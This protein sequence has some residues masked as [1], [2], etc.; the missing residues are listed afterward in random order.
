MAKLRVHDTPCMAGKREKGARSRRDNRTPCRGDKP[1][2]PLYLADDSCLRGAGA[3][4]ARL[5]A[6]ILVFT[7]LLIVTS[8]VSAYVG[9]NIIYGRITVRSAIIAAVNRK[10]TTTSYPN[11]GDEKFRKLHSKSSEAVSS[12][13]CASEAIWTT[14]TELLKNVVGFA[15]YLALLSTLQPAVMLVILATTLLGYFVSKRINEYAIATVMR[16]RTTK[17]SCGTPHEPRRTLRL[18][19]I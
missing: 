9:A 16:S 14:L 2:K 3:S 19:R 18:P 6:T 5:A 11:V 1:Y 4:V 12:N 13:S 7:G 17:T 8:A 15:I 10:A